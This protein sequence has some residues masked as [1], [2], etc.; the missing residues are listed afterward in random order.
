MFL[1]VINEL[2]MD[3]FTPEAVTLFLT[4]LDD[5]QFVEIEDHIMYKEIHKLS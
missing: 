4:L 2:E 1:Y 3:D 5:K